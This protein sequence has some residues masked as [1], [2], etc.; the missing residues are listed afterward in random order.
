MHR[1]H[2]LRHAK[3]DRDEGVED[4]ER[5]LSRRGRE[6]ARRVGES[7]PQALGTLDLVL[8]STALRI[9]E[10]AALVLVDFAP[11]Y[12]LFEDVLYLAG[13]NALLRRLCRLNERA[14]TVLVIG[15]NPG[16]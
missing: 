1:L 3:S 6:A 13:R 5:K 9:R 2:L 15:H 7:L 14:G 10:T 12:I 16:L 8:C 11:P 4:H